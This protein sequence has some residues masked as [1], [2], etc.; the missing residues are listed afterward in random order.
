MD[1]PLVS[2]I[3]ATYNGTQ[4]IWDAIDSVLS[5]DYKNLELIIVDDASTD[6][7]L[8]IILDAYKNQDTR[9]QIFRNEKNME[10]S[11]SKNFG[12]DQAKGNYIAFIDDDDIWASGKISAQIQVFN[13]GPH[14]WIV[15]TYARFID[16]RGGIL[17]ETHHLKI[18]PTDIQNTILFTN[19][20]IHSSVLIRKEIFQ[21]AW[22]FPIDMNLCE[23]YDLWLRIISFSR[24]IN[25]PDF[26]VQ[27][28]V[29]T[30]STTAKNIYRMKYRSLLLTVKY[31][32]RFPGFFTA[33][34]LKII[35]FPFNGVALLRLWKFVFTRSV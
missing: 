31:S 35:T 33:F 34:F 17:G 13:D 24:W 14:I 32:G 2:V 10:R 29:R 7:E 30:S 11:W 21:K 8:S 20:F 12:V 27:Y 15:G 19:Q 25:I 4:Y 23:D 28:R 18:D 5:Q 16:E 6:R 22:G 3:L 1:T 26:L 9:I